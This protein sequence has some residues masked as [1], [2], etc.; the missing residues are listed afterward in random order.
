MC[1]WPEGE[2]AEVGENEGKVRLWNED[3]GTI[4]RYNVNNTF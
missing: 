3:A 4:Q 1:P 2:R